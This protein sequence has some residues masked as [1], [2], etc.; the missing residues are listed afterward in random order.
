MKSPSPRSAE[1]VDDA[2]AKGAKLL[3]GGQRL[4][5]PGYYYP[6]TVLV[7]RAGQCRHDQGRDLRTGGLAAIASTDEAEAIRKAN[8]TEYGLAAYVY[9]QDLKRGMQIC[10]KLR[11]RH[12]GP[13]SRPDVGPGGA[14]RRRRSSRAWDREG[15]HH[16][17]IEFCEIKYVSTNW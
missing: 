11:S 14:V 2:I 4:N 15:S 9:A 1:L 16:G 5:R 3:L 12:A 6:P 13:Q 17:L 8:D 7:G 10:E